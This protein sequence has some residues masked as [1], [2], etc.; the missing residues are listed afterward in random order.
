[1]NKEL[2]L[3]FGGHRVTLS[4]LSSSTMIELS[5][6]EHQMK[7]SFGSNLELRRRQLFKVNLMTSRR[8]F[9]MQ[10][11]TRK[12]HRRRWRR[13]TCSSR[14]SS[15]SREMLRHRLEH[16]CCS[17]F[18]SIICHFA[19]LLT[20]SC[21]QLF[22]VL[23]TV[24]TTYLLNLQCLVVCIRCICTLE[25]LMQIL[26]NCVPIIVSIAYSYYIIISKSVTKWMVYLW[27]NYFQI[28]D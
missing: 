25:Y 13:P 11:K 6:L 1:M 7:V 5:S 4:Q 10:K 28:C 8:K 15:P 20:W 21:V 23:G 16:S 24:R 27:A 14:S 3:P 9:K 2:H 26:W 22:M 19:Y 17:A 12:G 18:L